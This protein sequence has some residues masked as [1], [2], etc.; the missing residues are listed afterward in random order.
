M[1]PAVEIS[2]VGP[3]DM[4]SIRAANKW[5]RAD[6][7]QRLGCVESTVWRMENGKIKIDGA[8]RILLSQLKEA[9]AA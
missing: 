1:K 5:S 9:S 2:K 3:E 4:A 7:A 8:H 6:L